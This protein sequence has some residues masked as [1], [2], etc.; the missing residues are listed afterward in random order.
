LKDRLKLQGLDENNNNN[1]NN[2]FT[3]TVGEEV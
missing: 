1:N 2:I 3:E